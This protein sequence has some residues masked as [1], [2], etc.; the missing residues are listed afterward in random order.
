MTIKKNSNHSIKDR[1]KT[2]E[3]TKEWV[4]NQSNPND[5]AKRIFSSTLF[6]YM[7]LE[8]LIRMRYK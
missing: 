3:S 4:N 7:A 1:A 8:I 6:V 5:A 2:P